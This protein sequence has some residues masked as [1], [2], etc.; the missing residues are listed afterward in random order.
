MATCTVML[1]TFTLPHPAPL[2]KS[3]QAWPDV[4]LLVALSLEPKPERR[5]RINMST[6]SPPVPLIIMCSVFS[7]L[8]SLSLSLFLSLSKSI[9]MVMI[10]IITLACVLLLVKSSF[11]DL[12]HQKNIPFP[13]YYTLYF[14]LSNPLHRAPEV[15]HIG[16]ISC[17]VH[18]LVFINIL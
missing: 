7:A 5:F 14:T 8:L 16:K 11:T 2:L 4:L 3:P 17:C 18:C 6:H 15:M 1:S 9:F 13:T 12:F 10:I